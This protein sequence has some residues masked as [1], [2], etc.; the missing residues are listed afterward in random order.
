MRF[1]ES[2][3]KINS[4]RPRPTGR[5]L[6]VWIINNKG[7]PPSK[8][9]LFLSN[10]NKIEGFSKIRTILVLKLLHY[11]QSHWNLEAQRVLKRDKDSWDVSGDNR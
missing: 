8:S 4:N 11:C 9:W 6:S 1:K 3:R 2:F 5:C 7:S 10:D